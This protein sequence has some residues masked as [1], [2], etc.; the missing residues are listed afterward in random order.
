MF[1]HEVHTYDT[2]DNN[3]MYIYKTKHAFAQ[4][5]LRHSLPFLVNNLP[6]IVKEKLVSHST[7]G[8]AKYV[9]LFLQ[10]Y[11]VACTIQNSYV[12]MQN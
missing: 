1:K 4:K 5:C 12:C 6:E 2:R 3:E 8:F 7:Q 11:K 10:S 9:K